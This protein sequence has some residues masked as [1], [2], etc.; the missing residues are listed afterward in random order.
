MNGNIYDHKED[1]MRV[2]YL[3]MSEPN[4]NCPSGFTQRQYNNIDHGV[5]GLPNSGVFI[6][7]FWFASQGIHYNKMCGQLKG[8]QYQSPDSFGH[9][10]NNIDFCYVG[11]ISST[12]M[13]VVHVNIFGHMQVV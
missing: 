1:W 4:A 11:G 13:V 6:H 10:T 3:N 8:Y 9:G 5:C 2:A 12:Y 7:T